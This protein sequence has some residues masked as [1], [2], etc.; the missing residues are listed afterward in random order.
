MTDVKHKAAAL[1]RPNLNAR[2]PL[3]KP[4]HRR[5][6]AQDIPNAVLFLGSNLASRTATE[7]LVINGGIPIELPGA[8]AT[9]MTGLES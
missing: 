9:R 7:S 3:Q 2:Q 6:D 8:I 4:A 5:G 1:P